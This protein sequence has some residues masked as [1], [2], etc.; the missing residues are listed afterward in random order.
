MFSDRQAAAYLDR[1]GYAGGTEPTAENL[2]ALQYAHLLA[3]PYEN[4]DILLGRPI[5]L[6]AEDIY[7]KVV[8]S[9]R[10]GYCF[11]L[12]RV[13]GELL[14]A[15]GYGVT[16][17]V[18]RF[19]RGSDGVPKRRHMV[20]KAVCRDGVFLTDVGVG[21]RIPLFP[22]PWGGE[23]LRDGLAVYRLSDAPTYGRELL[24]KSGGGWTRLYT[25]N[26]DVQLPEDFVFAS[27]WCE[28]AP[29][30]PFNK[31]YML[32]IRREGLE[33][34]TLDG[35]TLRRH[36]PEGVRVFTRMPFLPQ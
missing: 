28:A 4:L 25:F 23:E 30:S 21:A 10:G 16:D 3:V 27:Y 24:E 11:E 13:Y 6:R 9:R 2:R 35:R 14:R 8:V 18:S 7:S 22:T 31:Q 5:S 33:R 19:W 26:E 29:D 20:L 1:I 34:V 36:T 15:L 17:Y 12:N 32:S